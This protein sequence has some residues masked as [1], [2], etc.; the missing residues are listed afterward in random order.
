VD[1]DVVKV[2]DAVAPPATDFHLA[3]ARIIYRANLPKDRKMTLY[4]YI[5]AVLPVVYATLA[6][7]WL[8]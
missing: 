2:E 7:V 5:V 3:T 1:P 6:S 4:Q 8:P